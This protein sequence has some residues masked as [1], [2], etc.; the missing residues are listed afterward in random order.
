MVCQLLLL[1]LLATAVVQ[2]HAVQT[3]GQTDKVAH[4]IECTK[5]LYIQ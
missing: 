4:D 5:N 3:N 1:L 2:V